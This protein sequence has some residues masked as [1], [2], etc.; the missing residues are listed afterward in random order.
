MDHDHSRSPISYAPQGS[1][2]ALGTLP[3]RS[4]SDRHNDTLSR[5]DSYN[6]YS[7]H[8]PLRLQHEDLSFSDEPMTPARWALLIVCSVAIA[9]AMIIF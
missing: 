3:G 1:T 8:T 4:L 7:G 6:A 5:W 2:D 9:I